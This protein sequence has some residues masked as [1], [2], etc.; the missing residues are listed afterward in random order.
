MVS[1]IG[2]VVAIYSGI[3]DCPPL[4]VMDLFGLD[5]TTKESDVI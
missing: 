4:A 1:E 2:C 5:Q 3:V